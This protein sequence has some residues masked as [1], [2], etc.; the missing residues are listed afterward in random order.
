M[1]AAVT[2]LRIPGRAPRVL[3]VD[4]EDWFHVCGEE[5][6]SD[7]RRWTGFPSR[8]ETTLRT[9]FDL[10][11]GGGH[12]GTFFFL[13]WIAARY[14]DLVAEAA[15]RGHEIGV[16]GHL[17]RRSDD[18]SPADFADDLARALEAVERAGG[19]I[20]SAH[21]AAEWSIRAPSD[22]AFAV[23]VR[24]AIACDASMTSVP[25]L[26]RSDNHPGPQR[27]A[28]PGGAIV[29]VPP[30]TGRGFGRTLPMGGG[31][32]FRMF[33][34]ARISRAEESFRSAGWPAV[35][36]FHPWEFDSAHPPMEGL[37]PLLKLVHFFNLG[38]TLDRFERWLA[39]DRCVA[40]EDV[41][42]RLA[43]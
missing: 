7:P 20:P 2:P 35:F 12:R 26:G 37:P 40:L 22:P 5:Y 18:G 13:G 14:P 42:P 33:S 19:R 27:I 15:R 34:A 16:H 25:P 8:I 10:L 11:E 24:L 17:H 36:T 6:F 43:A 3:T 4:V 9:I 1:P 28:A 39:R 38:A 31:W 29:E 21:R 30:L 41:I 23:L 32:P